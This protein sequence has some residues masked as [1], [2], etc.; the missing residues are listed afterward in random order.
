M[1]K[2]VKIDDAV[3][4]SKL[5]KGL[6]KCALS[7]QNTAKEKAPVDSGKLRASIRLE[8][9]GD[10]YSIGTMGVPYA[11]F[12]EFG[13]GPMIRAHGKHDPKNPVVTWEALR[14]RDGVGQTLPFLRTALFE[15]K[16]DFPKFFKEV[17][18]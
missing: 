4:R 3:F 10:G 8:K 17:F 16:F 6:F 13:T 9:E 12:V 14:T 1:S 11:K 15:R 5:A 2:I 18:R 7:V